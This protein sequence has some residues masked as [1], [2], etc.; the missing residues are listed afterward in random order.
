MFHRTNPRS[1]L[2]TIFV[3][4]QRQEKEVPDNLKNRIITPYTFGH[5]CK[6]A[7]KDFILASIHSFSV[8][9][10]KLPILDVNEDEVKEVTREVMDE[11]K[12]VFR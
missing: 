7:G 2:G 1:F 8:Y 6:F 9:A 3:P 5:S 4:H 11:V 10:S 12:E